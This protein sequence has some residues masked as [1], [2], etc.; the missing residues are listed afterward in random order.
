MTKPCKTALFELY[1]QR[2]PRSGGFAVFSGGDELRAY[3]EDKG[4]AAMVRSV[5]EGG[6]IFPATP[7]LTVECEP[8]AFLSI[9][10]DAAQLAGDLCAQATMKARLLLACANAASS[11][12]EHQGSGLYYKSV[13]LTP[14][15]LPARLDPVSTRLVDCFDEEK[16]AFDYISQQYPQQCVLPVDSISTLKSGIPNAISV[17]KNCRQKGILISSGDIAY[18][19]IHGR[20]MLDEAGLEDC[21]IYAGGALDEFL[22]S[23]IRRQGAPVDAFCVD[24]LPHCNDFKTRFALSM[25]GAMPRMTR[26]QNVTKI[27][28]PARKELW[29]VFDE[30]GKALADLMTLDGEKLPLGESYTLFDPHMPWKKTRI[31]RLSATRILRSCHDETSTSLA[32]VEHLWDEVLRFENPHKYYVDYSQGLWELCQGMMEG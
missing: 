18:Q 17:L 29:R 6:A 8:L 12:A 3:L 20:K 15:A 28:P 26:S 24:S 30:N 21:K 22:I 4:V 5:P 11:A 9:A 14:S 2:N 19:A 10:E 32:G 7:V 27:T 13:R 1:F 16:H 25:A 23:A 31:E